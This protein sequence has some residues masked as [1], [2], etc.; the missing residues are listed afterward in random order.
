MTLHRFRWLAVV[1]TSMTVGHCSATAQPGDSA[2]PAGS[3]ITLHAQGGEHAEFFQNPHMHAFYE[4]SVAM[5]REPSVDVAAYE[6]R[7][8]EIFRA[9]ATSLGWHPE[10]LVDHLKNIPREVVGI[11]KD[12][13]KVLDSFESFLVALRGPP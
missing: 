11:V 9:L 2:V 1:V 5:L 7:S 12:D 8:Y 6:Q 10:G 4:L 13:A 3:S